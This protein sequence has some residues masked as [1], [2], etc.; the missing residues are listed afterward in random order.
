MEEK[1]KVIL[2]N[3][4][5]VLT[6]CLLVTGDG[7]GAAKSVTFRREG[8]VVTVVLTLLLPE[9]K[10]EDAGADPTVWNWRPEGTIFNGGAGSIGLVARL[11]R[12]TGGFTTAFEVLGAGASS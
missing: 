5:V 9:E 1:K 6:G 10:I 3:A 4:K 8:S 7:L 11:K 2:V 12:T